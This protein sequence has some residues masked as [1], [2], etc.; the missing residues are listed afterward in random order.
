ML[1]F[2]KKLDE[3]INHQLVS[4][5]CHYT[6]KYRSAAH[7]IFNLKFNVPKNIPIVFHRGCNYDYHFVIKEL[8]NDIDG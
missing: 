1:Y 2:I 5:H 4:E 3:D 6:G 8:A 7:S